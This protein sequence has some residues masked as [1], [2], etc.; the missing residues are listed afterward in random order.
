M[1]EIKCE[2]CGTMNR[3]SRDGTCRIPNAICADSF[4]DY[5]NCIECG[6]QILLHRRYLDKDDY[7]PYPFPVMDEC[8]GVQEVSE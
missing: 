6:C 7:S 8:V 3:A 5:M 2:V 4:M 1:I